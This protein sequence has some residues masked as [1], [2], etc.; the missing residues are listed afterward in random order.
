MKTLLFPYHDEE[1]GRSALDTAIHVARRFGSYL[2]GLLAVTA[3]PVALGPGMALAPDYLTQLAKEWRTFAVTAR[4][5]FV[6]VTS[7]QGLPFDD[8]QATDGPGAGWREV[9]G[10]EADA[11]GHIGRAFD[12]V[13][14]GRTAATSGSRWRET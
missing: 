8:R 13:V 11:V 7:E 2:E 14:L 1:A 10:R 5:H 9:D 4:E 3:P 12:L 6:R